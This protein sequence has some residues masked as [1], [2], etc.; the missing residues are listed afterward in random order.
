MAVLSDTVMTDL[1]VTHDLV[2]ANPISTSY[3]GTGTTGSYI[4]DQFLEYNSTYHKIYGISTNFIHVA[5]TQLTELATKAR[6][7]SFVSFSNSESFT[8]NFKLLG[9]NQPRDDQ[10]YIYPI[11]QNQLRAYSATYW[12]GWKLSIGV[13][14]ISGTGRAKFDDATIYIKI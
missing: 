4:N 5:E 9:F 2:L 11:D 6:N 1:R 7:V 8:S 3:G 13:Q 12:D 14:W 10:I